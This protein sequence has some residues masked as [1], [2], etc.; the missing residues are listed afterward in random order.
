MTYIC[1]DKCNF[2]ASDEDCLKH[3]L[4]KTEKDIDILQP[5]EL[6]D[7][8]YVG[9]CKRMKANILLVTEIKIKDKGDSIFSEGE[10]TCPF[11]GVVDFDSCEKGGSNDKE[12]CGT[13]GSIFSFT[14]EVEV[15]YSSEPVKK[16]EILKLP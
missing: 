11:C 13:C 6:N 16:C 2:N 10:I 7:K 3:L 9:T 4:Y 15:S 12:E 8:Y 14:R 1:R 5:F